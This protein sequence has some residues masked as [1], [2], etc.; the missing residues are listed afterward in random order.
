MVGP[1]GVEVRRPP[2]VFRSE[3]SDARWR[4]VGSCPRCRVLA[5]VRRHRD[6]SDGRGKRAHAA[7]AQSERLSSDRHHR[8]GSLYDTA[9]IVSRQLPPYF[10][11]N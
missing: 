8:I 11:F 9:E 4:A 5:G 6:R 1:S 2:P 7:H 10:E 3:S